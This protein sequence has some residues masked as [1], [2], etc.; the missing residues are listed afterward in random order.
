MAELNK[1]LFLI[2]LIKLAKKNL[3]KFIL[4]ENQEVFMLT[5]NSNNKKQQLGFGTNLVINKSVVDNLKKN[6]QDVKPIQDFKNYLENDGKNWVAELTYDKFE[7][8][9][10]TDMDIKKLLKDYHKNYDYGK[11]IMARQNIS[12][13]E[14]QKALEVIEGIVNDKSNDRY[15]KS[16]AIDLIT[17][18]N[19]TK[20]A[21]NLLEKFLQSPNDDIKSEAAYA[22][23]SF[24][25]SEVQKELL[26]KFFNNEDIT[27]KQ[28]ISRGIY[29]LKD[30]ALLNLYF[31]KIYNDSD[32]EIKSYALYTI[33]DMSEETYQKNANK[34]DSIIEESFNSKEDVIREAAALSLGKISDEKKAVEL[35]YKMVSS[36]INGWRKSEAASSVKYIKNPETAKT[37]IIKLLKNPESEVREGATKAIMELKDEKIQNELLNLVME[38][39]SFNQK[40]EI[41]FLIDD[42]KD[43]KMQSTIFNILINDPEDEIRE[44][45]SEY[46]CLSDNFAKQNEMINKYIKTDDLSIKKGILSAITSISKDN[47]EYA[48]KFLK[49]LATDENEFIQKRAK[50]SLENIKQ[51]NQ[52]DGY[53][54]K[55]TDAS[56]LIGKKKIKDE[57]NLFDKLFQA[58]KIVFK[59]DAIKQ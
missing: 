18:I 31:D 27:I 15:E 57:N 22:I 12:K 24:K 35:I 40:R 25:N 3:F 41:A 16:N 49:I 59:N 26:D 7:K 44:R 42:I 36:D 58:Y 10:Q 50:E 28:S 33:A 21:V 17:Y 52:T 37:V 56:N 43:E 20:L 47:P 11:I 54:L 6:P 39:P 38:K 1:T 45:L 5:I 53:S 48:E 30:K 8:S 14:P 46:T 23:F 9:E 19:D 29:K 2:F 55:I 13:L 51:F 32:P 4:Y 34:Y